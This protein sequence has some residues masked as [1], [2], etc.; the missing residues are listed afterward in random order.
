MTFEKLSREK[1]YNDLKELYDA[2]RD[3]A[4]RLEHVPY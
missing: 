4:T 3:E 1:V 2:A